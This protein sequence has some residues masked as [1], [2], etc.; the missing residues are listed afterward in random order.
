MGI[1]DRNLKIAV[2]GGGLSG[3]SI[4]EGLIRRG[5]RNVTLF[6]ASDRL[7]GK[8]YSINYQSKVY[9]L[10]AIF[11]LP[12]QNNL[13]KLLS[14]LE[15]KADGPK[16][17]RVYYN[18]LGEKILQIP[19]E[20]LKLFLI[21]LDRLPD[22][23]DL[24]PCLDDPLLLMIDPAL[25]Q[26]FSKWCEQFD[27]K[28]LNRVYEHYFISYGLGDVNEVP[29]IYVLKILNY[30]NLMSFIE[31]PEFS[32]WRE[33]T[34]S[35][36]QKL[37]MEVKDIRLGQRVLEVISQDS[38]ELSIRTEFDMETFDYVIITSQLE[39]FYQLFSRDTQLMKMVRSIRY[40]EYNVY[41]FIAEKLPKGCGCIIDNL[42]L[43]RKGH[44]VIWNSGWE[45][46]DTEDIVIVYAYSMD[47]A[48]SQEKI[49]MIKE[50][51]I[52]QGVKKPR[53]HQ[54]IQW[55]QCPY[56]NQETLDAGFYNKLETFQGEKGLFFAGEILSTLSMNN[57]IKYTDYFLQKYF[58]TI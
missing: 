47:G 53:L 39:Q 29:A 11:L 20:D 48:T 41:A 8:L 21:E 34:T 42:D 54:M 45:V 12:T 15:L 52:S 3:L 58:E 56:V 5:F 6:E 14:R 25:S 46:S 28:V 18:N 30:D 9:E 24:F 38:G 4:S 23:L 40:S 16:L 13:K 51:L 36:I 31:I 44:L 43:S 32:T 26:S 37:A 22:V 50:D 17:S 27:F 33:G 35:I 19:K 10:G 55:H 57:C 2:V 1:V 49:A 7:G